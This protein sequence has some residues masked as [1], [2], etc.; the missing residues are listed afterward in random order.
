MVN[1]F[2]LGLGILA[3]AYG[4]YTLYARIVSQKTFGKLDAMKKV[5]GPKT[6]VFIHLFAYTILPIILGIILIFS[7]L[8]GVSIL[9]L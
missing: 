7:G 1:F 9:A 6:G 5:W 8:K 3:L 4:L 2:T